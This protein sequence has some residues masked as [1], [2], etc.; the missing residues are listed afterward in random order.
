MFLKDISFNAVQ[1]APLIGVNRV[2]VQSWCKKGK[3]KAA[4]GING[5]DW[6][7]TGMAFADFLYF[8]PKYQNFYRNA[9]FLG[10]RKTTRD[11]IIQSIDARPLIFDMSLLCNIFDTDYDIIDYWVDCGEL[12]ALDIHSVYRARLFDEEGVREFVDKNPKFARSFYNYVYSHK[13]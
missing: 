5:R 8:N 2:S 11:I 13:L 12:N 10:N 6:L 4:K 9:Y 1:I 3:I 7:I